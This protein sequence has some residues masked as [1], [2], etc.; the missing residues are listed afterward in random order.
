MNG[1]SMYHDEVL[2]AQCLVSMS[3]EPCTTDYAQRRDEPSTVSSDEEYPMEGDNCKVEIRYDRD[4]MIPA[5]AL[6]DPN[7]WKREKNSSRQCE[8]TQVWD[9]KM[10]AASRHV[11]LL[12]SIIPHDR[13]ELAL[14][15]FH[16]NDYS[17]NGKLFGGDEY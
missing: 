16:E 2:V 7:H 4:G 9:S 10:G 17:I 1:I 3:K 14:S 15:L 13:R 12:E 5:S 8:M 11:E 6:P